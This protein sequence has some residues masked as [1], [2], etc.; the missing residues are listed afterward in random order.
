MAL[1]T[2]P[3]TADEAEKQDFARWLDS[4]IAQLRTS[5]MN[6]TLDNLTGLLTSK[7]YMELSA[8]QVEGGYPSQTAFMS[9]APDLRKRRLGTLARNADALEFSMI[10]Y[11]D[12]LAEEDPSRALALVGDL[13]RGTTSADFKAQ[14]A[15]VADTANKF[16]TLAAQK[17]AGLAIKILPDMPSPSLAPDGSELISE[18]EPEGEMLQPHEPK[19]RHYKNR[20]SRALHDANRVMMKIINGEEA[21]G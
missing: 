20:R 18:E 19:E 17:Q 8:S 16:R 21:G 4:A 11:L 2:L 10:A 7:A 9:M 13:S 1:A 6:D 14:L 15:A 12:N 5:E 3:P